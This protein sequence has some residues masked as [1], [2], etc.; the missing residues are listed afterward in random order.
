M[1]HKKIEMSM[2]ILFILLGIAAFAYAM[3]IPKEEGMFLKII[4]LIMIVTSAAIL[5]FVLREQKNVVNMEGV[6]LKKVIVT[7]IVLCAYALV[8]EFA[9]YLAATFVLAVFTIRYLNYKKWAIILGFAIFVT[10]LTY[11]IFYG[12]LSVPLPTPFF[13]D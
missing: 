2:P 11:G 5:Y 10:L 3:T 1:F 6:D 8:L 7:V 9:G 4:A 13:I 12:L